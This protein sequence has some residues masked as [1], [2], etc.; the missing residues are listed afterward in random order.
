MHRLGFSWTASLLLWFAC[1]AF[2]QNIYGTLNGVVLDPSGSAVPGVQGTVTDQARGTSRKFTTGPDGAFVVPN[3]PPGTY[4]V[5]I[6]AGGFKQLTI[7]DLVLTSGENRSLGRL[8]MEVG[9][10]VESVTVEAQATPLQTTSS[11]R[12][13]L[14]TGQQ[15]NDIAVKGRD[16]ASYLITI[17]GVVDTNSGGREAMARNALGS[18]HIN[19]G[20]GTQVLMTVDGMPSM[21][22]GNNGVPNEPNMDS[23]AEVKIMTTNYQAEYGRNAGGLVSVITKSGSKEFHG[24][25]Y[26]FYRHESLNANSF[27]NNRTGTPKA[28]YRYRITGYSIGGP[29]IVPKAAFNKNK[30]KL[31]FFFSQEL[32]GSRNNWS[33]V[34]VNMPTQLERNG[35][36]SKSLD[37]NGA[38]IVVKD[39]TT[40]K[41]FPGNV[42]PKDRIDKLG[43][44]MLNF[45]PLPNYTDP[46]PN[47]VNRRNYRTVPSGGWPR[48]QEVLRVDYN[49]TSSF[50]VFYRLLE[51]FN[52]LLL[53][54]GSGG[55]P[56]GSVN[57]LLSP[58]MWDRP[59]RAQAVHATNILSNSLVN[60]ATFTKSMN[61]VIFYP[62]N[63]SVLAGR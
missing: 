38:L 9:G 63:P 1:P 39:P 6:R 57:Y 33:P 20:R 29:I 16:F 25:A 45:L 35:D 59:A 54:T 43:Q 42:V 55:W 60:D 26:D 32:V 4:E 48:R 13:G 3:M 30:D 12:S 53:Q 22:A 31:F 27:F 58:I 46:D 61:N 44:A 2:G 14:V 21:D 34:F 51:D 49:I 7:R 47:Y 11:E 18:I 37:V 5:S 56:A 62:T 17:P 36:F 8:T 24:S 23:I 28:P 50:Q 15:V 10:V 40:G 19:G 52:Q 41:P